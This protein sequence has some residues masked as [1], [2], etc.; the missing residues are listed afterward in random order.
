MIARDLRWIAI[1]GICVLAGGGGARAQG[2]TRV[3]FSGSINDFTPP[4]IGSWEVHG[5]WSLSLQGD[6]GK[7]DFSADLTM[8]HSDYWVLTGGDPSARNPHTH[9]V[10]VSGGTVTQTQT[11]FRVDG[12]AVVTG[13]GAYP[14]P[15]GEPSTLAIE[16]SGGNLVPFSNVKLTFG[17]RAAVHF[18]TQSFSGVV[19]DPK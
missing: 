19:A 9:H 2:P 15:F 14:P 6:S 1:V 8:E 18:G 13:N 5:D 7:A 16:I 3:N 4:S 10:T 11:G 12:A 17:G